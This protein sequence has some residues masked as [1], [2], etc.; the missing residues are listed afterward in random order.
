MHETT[1][2]DGSTLQEHTERVSTYIYLP[3][4]CVLFLSKMDSNRFG[5]PMIECGYLPDVGRPHTGTIFGPPGNV[6]PI[7]SNGDEKL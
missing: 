5:V 2:K 6:T 3:V 4:P 1:K 7:G